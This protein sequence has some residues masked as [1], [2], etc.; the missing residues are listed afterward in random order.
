MHTAFS[1]ECS[2]AVMQPCAQSVPGVLTHVGVHQLVHLIARQVDWQH[3]D[4][5][6]EGQPRKQVHACEPSKQYNKA[7]KQARHTSCMQAIDCPSLWI[8]CTHR[9]PCESPMWQVHQSALF[10]QLQCT[11]RD[12]QGEVLSTRT[13]VKRP[14]PLPRPCPRAHT[15]TPQGVWAF[16]WHDNCKH[17]CTLCIGGGRMMSMSPAPKRFSSC[18]AN[19]LHSASCF[20]AHR[21]AAPSGKWQCPGPPHR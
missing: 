12:C 5:A 2:H 13:R 3:R 14:L 17:V 21:S 1:H 20:S 10:I 9:C 15:T 16:V 19:M 18:A 11:A 8:V 7:S 4:D 6:P